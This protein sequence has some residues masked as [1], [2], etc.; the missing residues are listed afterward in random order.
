M[1][2]QPDD[3]RD[4]A[5]LWRDQPT[6]TQPMTLAQIHARDFQSRIRRRNVIEYVACAIVVA[7]FCYYIYWIPD[8]VLKVASGLIAAAAAFVAWQLHRRA[9]ARPTP[10]ADALAFHRAE[11]VRQHEALSKAWAW[12]LAPFVP[13]LGLFIVRML[14]TQTEAPIQ[15]RAMLPVL[16]A[17]Y[18][19][20][21]FWVNRRARRRLDGFIAEID[22]LR[23]DAP[24]S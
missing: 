8:P 11:L 7:T 21:W 10:G 2:G 18:G 14:T 24:R 15:A 16:T 22:A 9:A 1:T 20:A 5:A 23:E 19:V 6:E 17:L 3:P 12:Y 13:G 4:I